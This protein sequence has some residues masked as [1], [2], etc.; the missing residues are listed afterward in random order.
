MEPLCLR[1]M[2]LNHCAPESQKIF[3]KIKIGGPI[4][5]P[6][7]S[8]LWEGEDVAGRA[9]WGGRCFIKIPR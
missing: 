8:I 3:K 1:A 4:P 2:N 6:T 7:E 5:K 9:G